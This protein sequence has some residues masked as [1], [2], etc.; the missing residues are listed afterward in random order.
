MRRLIRSLDELFVG[1][2]AE[3]FLRAIR[4]SRPTLQVA[5]RSR[6]QS[7]IFSQSAEPDLLTSLFEKYGSDKSSSNEIGVHSYAHILTPT[8]NQ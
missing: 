5:G 6:H 8:W 2:R 1:G 7:S 4:I 3:R